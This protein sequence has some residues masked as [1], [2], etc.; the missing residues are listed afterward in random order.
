MTPRASG[1]DSPRRLG[2]GLEALLGTAGR[3]AGSGPDKGDNREGDVQRI[4]IAEIRPNPFQP[5]K[6]FAPEELAELAASL[7]A[8]GLLQPITVRPV[9]IFSPSPSPSPSTSP[10]SPSSV[11]GRAS[12]R[13]SVE[14]YELIAGE[15]RLRA[16]TQVGW[17]EIP[18]IV[19]EIDDQ[20]ALTLALVENLQRTD[21]N[22][23]EEAEG[24]ARLAEDFAIT[25]QQIAD[26]VGKNRSTVANM[27]RLLQLPASVRALLRDGQ[28]TPGHGRALLAL[29]TEREILAATRQIIA[30]SLSVRTAED[31]SRRKPAT[32]SKHIKATKSSRWQEAAAKQIEERLRR[33]LQTDVQ[34]SLT[35]RD[36]GQ[37]SILF[38]S[39]DDLER[40]LER[41]LG[42]PAP[43]ETL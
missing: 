38:Y 25:Q 43:H 30:K 16:A 7:K 36:R 13:A 24:Y 15:R 5:R 12:A 8:S 9:P 20:A 27:L 14:R 39:N 23:I 22:P 29:E 34:I 3:P 32:A 11:A 26:V 42:A 1:S 19:R 41:I 35:G 31:L 17:S 10:S 2:R 28:L 4:P 18:A 37:V 40:L 6:D 21:L 33:F